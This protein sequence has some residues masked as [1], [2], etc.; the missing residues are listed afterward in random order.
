MPEVLAAYTAL[1]RHAAATA[2][3]P[4]IR[5][6]AETLIAQW[7]QTAPGP[8]G[9]RAVQAAL[10]ELR[11]R[12]IQA[13]RQAHVDGRFFEHRAL[14]EAIAVLDGTAGSRDLSL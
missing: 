13:A 5:P 9:E 4:S 10:R 12:L 1:L 11:E 2:S 14:L 8:T 6:L 7:R 3:P